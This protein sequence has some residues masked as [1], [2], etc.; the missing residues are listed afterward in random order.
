[1]NKMAGNGFVGFKPS[2]NAS[3]DL[4]FGT[5]GSQV[6]KD[7][8]GL[9]GTKLNTNESKSTYANLAARWYDFSLRSS[10]ISGND[11]INYNSLNIHPNQYNYTVQDVV[12][13]YA[14]KFKGKYTITPG[15][16]YQGIE[17]N[18]TKYITNATN[19]TAGFYNGKPT[20][21]NIAGFLR[22]D[23]NLT[24]RWRVLAA[25]RG[26]KFSNPKKPYLA[27]ELATTYKLNEDNLIRVAVTRSNSSSFMGSSKLNIMS[28]TPLPG[29]TVDIAGNSNLK[30]Q[31]IQMV[32]AG[33]R[34]KLSK[35][36]QLDLDVFRQRLENLSVIQAQVY[37]PIIKTAQYSQVTNLPTSAVQYGTTLSLNFVASENLQ[38]KPFITVQHTRTY[39][40]PS[41]FA[42]ASVNPG[43]TYSSSTHK[44]TPAVYGGYYVNYRLAARW[45]I[46]MNGYYFSAQRQY[47][48]SDP[49][50][51]SP[52]G[53]ISG[54]VLVNAKLNWSATKQ[55]SLF[56]NARNAFNSSAREI[57]GTDHING[58]YLVGASFSL[59]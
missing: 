49:T 40:L 44:S 57:F 22:T 56:A 9:N 14:A 16:S 54:K 28:P 20:L 55:L 34:S 32:E 3:F 7:Y 1:M 36:L 30:L 18:D 11:N 47:D 24:D 2:D 39:D 45:N 37:N 13:E 8:F 41:A 27:Y 58:I 4:S 15:V 48:Q 25:I 12:A 29:V 46:N 59:N 6:Q 50:G 51:V 42:T 23:L 19:P 43:L 53:H 52:Y 10:I 35:N 38:I 17:I 26:D 31:T 21:S 5:Q 33:Y